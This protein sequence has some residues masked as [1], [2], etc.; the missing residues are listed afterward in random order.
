MRPRY[1]SRLVDCVGLPQPPLDCGPPV[2]T[3]WEQR[4]GRVAGEEGRVR[5]LGYGSEQRYLESWLEP[6]TRERC[7]AGNS[8]V[9]SSRISFPLD[10]A[11]YEAAYDKLGCREGADGATTRTSLAE[12]GATLGLRLFSI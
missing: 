11:A 6:T 9:C 12:L 8:R 2:R 7:V 10:L 1:R 5:S 3:G 4:C